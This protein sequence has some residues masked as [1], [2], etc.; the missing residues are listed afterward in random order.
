MD[1][2]TSGYNY[3]KNKMNNA[4][5]ILKV[6]LFRLVINVNCYGINKIVILFIYSKL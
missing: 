2:K 5:N 1:F 4:F 3:L 6:F